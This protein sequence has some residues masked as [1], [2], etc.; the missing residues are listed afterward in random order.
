MT[1]E[2]DGEKLL[3]RALQKEYKG[4][5]PH[6]KPGQHRAEVCGDDVTYH[7]V[8][9]YVSAMGHAVQILCKKTDNGWIPCPGTRARSAAQATTFLAQAL[10]AN[11][12]LSADSANAL[13]AAVQR[14][15]KDVG[16]P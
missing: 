1:F 2:T 4:G 9:G 12:S 7:A 13:D 10:P 14:Y 15:E 16:S 11:F 8:L 6:F 3:G 5:V